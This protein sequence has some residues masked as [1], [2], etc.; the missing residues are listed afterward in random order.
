MGEV[1]ALGGYQGCTW[2]HH[3]W[4]VGAPWMS[5]VPGGGQQYGA[6]VTG[7]SP[8]I[9]QVKWPGPDTGLSTGLGNTGA[10]W[11]CVCS[12]EGDEHPRHLRPHPAITRCF[13]LHW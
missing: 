10:P 7:M 8:A 2:M 11:S 12:G 9:G 4:T 6:D 5:L 3:G 13:Q 1:S